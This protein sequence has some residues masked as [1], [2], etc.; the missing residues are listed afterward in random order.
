[1]ARTG[2]PPDAGEV[3]GPALPRS[4]FA[5][6]PLDVAPDLLGRVLVA[7]GPD[8]GAAVAVRLTE[9]EAYRGADDPASHAFRGRTR[10]TAVMFGPAGHLYLYFVY[11]MHWC[12]NVVTGWD[13][14]ASAV[15]LRA[16]R[17]VA[18]ADVAAARRAARRRTAVTAGALARGPAA[19]T[20]VLGLD[21]GADGADLCAAD[22]AV[23]LLP[24]VPATAVRS[25]PRVGV[26]AAAD[27]P[28]RFWV[29]GDP[30]VTAYRA[31]TRAQRRPP[32]GV[33][34]AAPGL[35]EPLDAVGDGRME[36]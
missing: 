7:G 17:V 20:T 29:D 5:R 10:R 18:G 22:S 26:S 15:L 23:R 30:T 19:L 28:W 34:R 9:V 25:G 12:V 21:A 24:G 33:T 3:A 11:G 27:R 2:E 32:A 36:G 16:G 1:M 14:E 31:G 4:F 8:A 6:D 35:R 13:G